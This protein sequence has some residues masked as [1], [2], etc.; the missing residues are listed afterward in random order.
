LGVL[1]CTADDEQLS[2]QR[3][4][5][6]GDDIRLDGYWYHWHM[7]SDLQLV[8]FLYR[9]GTL[10]DASCYF[11]EGEDPEDAI[12]SAEW[13]RAV[14]ERRFCWGV[15]VVDS[16]RIFLEKWTPPVNG[17]HGVGRKVGVIFDREHIHVD[18]VLSPSTGEATE[19]DQ[20]WYFKEFSPK[21]DHSNPFVK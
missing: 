9:D 11:G 15:F 6:E 17:G 18:S 4:R 3:T 5:Y 13:Q 19:L 12:R 21:P 10:L 7:Y 2:L 14:Q 16:D 1:A 20:D 8:Y